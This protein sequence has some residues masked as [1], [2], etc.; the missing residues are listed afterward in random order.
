METDGI[1]FLDELRAQMATVALDEGRATQRP[2]RRR[3]HRVVLVAAAAVA[4][5]LLGAVAVRSL[6]P[7]PVAPEPSSLPT[8]AALLALEKIGP[9]QR[10]YRATQAL[11][12][13]PPGAQWRKLRLP[14]HRNFGLNTGLIYAL[15]YAKYAWFREWI[16]AAQAGDR[17]RIAAAGAALAGIR[18]LM[19]LWR[20]GLPE[21]WGGYSQDEFWLFDRVIADAQAGQMAGIQT[22]VDGYERLFGKGGD[23]VI[24]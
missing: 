5:A 8:G 21:D 2:R 10:Q 1:R 16:A 24:H 22:E 17:Q 7:Q 4:V 15:D 12:E 6:A 20:E 3:K 18:Q 9:T 19:P 13:L 11:I 14:G 23:T